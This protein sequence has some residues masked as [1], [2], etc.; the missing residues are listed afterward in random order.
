M[1]KMK[2]KKMLFTIV[3]L[4]AIIGIC[5][6]ISVSADSFELRPL[7]Y[8][9]YGSELD[10]KDEIEIYVS[11]SG[12][13]NVNIMNEYQYNYLI[14]SGGLI[15]NYLLRWK[16]I[17]YLEYTYTIPVDGTYYVIIYN[18]NLLYTRVVDVDKKINYYWIKGI[19]GILVTVGVIAGLFSIVLTIILV[20]KHKKKKREAGIQHQEVIK[21]K[22]WYCS[23]CGAKVSDKERM[24]CSNCGSKIIKLI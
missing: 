1:D 6:I 2:N 3:L 15:W 23:E 10:Y 17:T 8:R 22:S 18:K 4:F 16:D 11:S 14:G 13:V 19:V 7:H 5:N 20:N 9:V 21:P 12:T 24:F